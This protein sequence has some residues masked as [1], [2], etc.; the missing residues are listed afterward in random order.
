MFA[1][2]FRSQQGF[3]LIEVI[4]AL[5]LTTLLLGLLS[6]GVY[7]VAEDW[8]RNTDV[9]D[10][11]LD[12][13]LAVL[14]IDRALHGVLAHSYTNIQTLS[15]QIYFIGED[16]ELSFV[17]TVSPQ[18]EPGLTAWKLSNVDDEGVYVKL[19][20]AYA[21][22]PQ[23]RLDDSEGTLLLP[24]YT[25]EFR[26]LYEDTADSYQWIDEWRGE[27]LQQLPFAVYVRFEPENDDDEALEIVAPIKAYRHR[28]ITPNSGRI[29]SL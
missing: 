3:T 29:Q 11:S 5:A 19:V 21:D 17:S 1:N 18:R 16:D 28:Q 27:E 20:P 7:I 4:L 15:R 23:E 12:E 13:A 6:T 26:Y 2:K 25:V 9:L 14:Q 22:N 24:N 8:N 10:E